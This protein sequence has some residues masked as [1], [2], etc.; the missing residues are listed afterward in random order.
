[1]MNV[2]V[3][4]HWIFRVLLLSGM[5]FIS[6]CQSTPKPVDANQPQVIE[7]GAVRIH[8]AANVPA[9]TL[10]FTNIGSKR[11]SG[12]EWVTFQITNQS[13]Q[14]S[15]KLDVKSSWLDK[16]RIPIVRENDY[17]DEIRIAPHGSQGYTKRAPN[18]SA[19][20][21]VVNI[22]CNNCP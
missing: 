3:N 7:S 14:V 15:M 2:S 13:K 16:N 18:S 21:A 20:Y 5:V 9:N 8:V 12:F 17:P 10:H 6:A 1:M 4:T 19:R 22:S 11:K